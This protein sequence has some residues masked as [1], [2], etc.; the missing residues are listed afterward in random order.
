MK[1]YL[2]VLFLVFCCKFWFT[3]WGN[4]EPDCMK[5]Q[6]AKGYD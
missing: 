3:M 5:L 6:L 4:L 2:V 1:L